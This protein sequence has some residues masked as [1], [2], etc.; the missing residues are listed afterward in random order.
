MLRYGM[1]FVDQGADFHEVKHRQR[2]INSLQWKAA[3]L[4]FQS[5]RPQLKRDVSG[6]RPDSPGWGLPPNGNLTVVVKCHRH[7]DAEKPVVIEIAW[8]EKEWVGRLHVYG[9]LSAPA[10]ES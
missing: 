1:Q 9:P 5:S 10:N 7:S 2:E 3:K 4:G 8:I 6:E